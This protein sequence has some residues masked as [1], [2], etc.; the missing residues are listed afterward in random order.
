MSLLTLVREQEETSQYTH[1]DQLFKEL[2][3]TFFSEFLEVFFPEVY[4]HI[5]FSAVHPLSE[6][7]LPIC[8]RE[9]IVGLI[10]LWK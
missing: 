3:H 2:I 8:M 5:D 7:F 1:H 4:E 9:K 10:L 6:E